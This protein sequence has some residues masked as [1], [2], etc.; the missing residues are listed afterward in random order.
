MTFYL[1]DPSSQVDY[2]LD[3]T[4]YLDGQVIAASA[5][6]VQPAEPGGVIV[7]SAGFDLNRAAARIAGGIAGHVYSVTNQVT[8]SDGSVD[9][10]SL[11]V[12]VEQR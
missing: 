8:L 9:A 5:W 4:G 11:V 6:S 10:R 1:K 7:A 12:R 2:A 3:W